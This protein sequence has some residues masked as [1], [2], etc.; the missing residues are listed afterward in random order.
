[1]AFRPLARKSLT[2]TSAARA[3]Q[4]T[5]TTSMPAMLGGGRNWLPCADDGIR[6]TFRCGS[7]RAARR[8]RP[9]T[10]NSPAY[11][12]CAPELGCSEIAS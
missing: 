6:H 2:S 11:S 10:A 1:M 7:P 3:S 8:D 5:T 4:V 9:R 12:P